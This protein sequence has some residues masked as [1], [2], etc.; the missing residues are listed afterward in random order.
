MC[1]ERDGLIAATAVVH[2]LT[3]ATRNVADFK[4]MGIALFNPWIE[5]T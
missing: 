2:G 5:Q 4:A 3:V 1:A